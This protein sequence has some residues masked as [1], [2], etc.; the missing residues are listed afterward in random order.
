MGYY[1]DC[2][3][4]RDV[5]QL[6][7]GQMSIRGILSLVL[8]HVGDY[9]CEVAFRRDIRHMWVYRLYNCVMLCSSQLDKHDEVWNTNKHVIM[10]KQT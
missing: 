5:S 2:V 10:S 1:L 6:A 4:D 9:I 3:I 7:A 8:Y